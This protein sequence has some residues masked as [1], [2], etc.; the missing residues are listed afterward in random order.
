MNTIIQAILPIGIVGFV[1][2]VLALI[3]H[4]KNMLK[5]LR[6]QVEDLKRQLQNQPSFESLLKENQNLERRLATEKAKLQEAIERG[7]RISQD[8]VRNAGTVV[9]LQRRVDFLK[10]ALEH[11]GAGVDVSAI[12]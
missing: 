7:D 1:L 2:Y 4:Y 9:H 5:L 3:T 8:R 12:K 11:A 10:L 6:A